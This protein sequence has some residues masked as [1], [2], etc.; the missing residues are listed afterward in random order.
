MFLGLKFKGLNFLD[1]LTQSEEHETHSTFESTYASFTTASS[2][3]KSTL[4][5]EGALLPKNQ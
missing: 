1:R 2:L 5:G 4:G 3:G